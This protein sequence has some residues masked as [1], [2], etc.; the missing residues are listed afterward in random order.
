MPRA[1]VPACPQQPGRSGLVSRT[2]RL[3]WGYGRGR[4][5]SGAT[6]GPDR[7]G[8]P[9]DPPARRVA[10]APSPAHPRRRV[11]VRRRRCWCRHH[12]PMIAGVR[13]RTRR[14]CRCFRWRSS[15]SSPGSALRRRCRPSR[16][17]RR[18][19]RSRA[20]GPPRRRAPRSTT[21][22]A[23]VASAAV[24]AKSYTAVPLAELLSVSGTSSAPAVSCVF[25]AASYAHVFRAVERAEERDGLVR[26]RHR[27][28]VRRL[29]RA[30]VDRLPLR[31]ASA[32]PS[33]L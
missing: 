19:R 17:P 13:A 9:G 26:D 30:R 1:P 24:I 8:L 25:V 22:P 5:L 7:R 32:L 18:R 28:P 15:A 20:R 31:L 21:L 27:L 4:H 6:V 29:A 11:V 3:A 2:P 14:R 23:V 33:V 16:R 10:A 12:R